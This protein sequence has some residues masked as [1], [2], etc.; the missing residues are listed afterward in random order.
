MTPSDPEFGEGRGGV[1]S[2]AP[3]MLLN[4]HA[5]SSYKYETRMTAYAPTR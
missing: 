1:S 2:T 3:D 4:K 5:L